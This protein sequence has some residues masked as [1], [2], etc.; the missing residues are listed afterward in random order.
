LRIDPI[1]IVI[2][3]ESF[4]D[5]EV[6]FPEEVAPVSDVAEATTIVPPEVAVPPGAVQ[7]KS[8]ARRAFQGSVWTFVGYG[9]G[10]TIRFVAN[11]VLTHYLFPRAFGLMALINVLMQGLQMFSDLGIGPAIIKHTQSD[12]SKFFNTAWTMQVIRGFLLWTTACVLAVP[13]A[14][15]Y[16]TPMLASMI[17]VAALTAVL[18]GFNSTKLFIEG[19]ELRLARVISIEILAQIVSVTVMIGLAKYW[20]SVWALVLGGLLGP[21]IKMPLSHLV[22]PG[23]RN[24][25]CWDR[26]SAHHL[27]H[28]GRWIFVS[29]LFTF[30]AMQSDRLL[31][32]R[33]DSIEKLGIYSIALGLVMTVLGV[34]EQFSNRILMPAMAHFRRN[35]RHNFGDVVRR[36]R[37]YILSLAAIAIAD[38]I[39]LAP[40]LFYL[41]Y[42]SRYH[43]AGLIARWLGFGLWFTLLQRTSQATL[44]AM[45]HSK[46]MALA[47][48]CNFLITI[49]AAPIGFYMFGI[50]GF[51]GGWTLGNLAAA[52][53]VDST[54]ARDGIPMLRQDAALTAGLWIFVGIGYVFRRGL[55][56]HPVFSEFYWLTQLLPPAVLSMS[57]AALLHWEYRK[58]HPTFARSFHGEMTGNVQAVPED[59]ASVLSNG[60]P[61]GSNGRPHERG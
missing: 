23:M 61:A 24:R 26:E 18:S 48:A 45:G 20:G 8:Y 38:L 6:S 40:A 50:K 12:D 2:E 42:D 1:D 3:Q 31:L 14:A 30:L 58:S 32:G 36:S 51:I 5:A 54:L 43:E 49:V 4:V 34:F 7:P 44:L 16:N 22:L 56:A 17:P 28:F 47:N 11:I 13:V 39:L 59:I 55:H 53:I 46:A 52:A 57:C 35:S 33:L 37:K 15:F 21:M 29:T 60:A 41:L 27:Y 9:G 25:F 10:Q 19:R